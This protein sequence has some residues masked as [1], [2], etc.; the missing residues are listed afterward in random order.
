MAKVRIKNTDIEKA[1]GK[2][3]KPLWKTEKYKR[4]VIA[5]PGKPDIVFLES[6]VVLF[7]DGDF[8]HGKHFTKWK[9]KVSPFWQEKIAG[10]IKRDRLQSRT[11][12]KE[13]Y[14]VFRFYGSDIKRTP[15]KIR[16]ILK[17]SLK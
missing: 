15:E 6:K 5:L 8:W 9:A 4:N 2:I 3:V 11:L 17:N 10:N 12:R 1:L 7:A 16:K 14:R 13:G